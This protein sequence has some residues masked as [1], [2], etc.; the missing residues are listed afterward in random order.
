M[1]NPKGKANISSILIIIVL[2]YGAFL[3][4]KF[5]SSRVTKTQIKTEILEKLGYIRGPEFTPEKGE[6]II[7]KILID[8]NL[9]SEDASEGEVNENESE[10]KNVNA[11][12]DVTKIKVEVQQGGSKIRF[13]VEYMDEI[14]LLLFKTKAHYNIEEEM[15]NYF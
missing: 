13:T 14:D 2:G 15:L 1:R 12:S 10:D 7:R 6:D 4:F 5:I 11:E 9:Y 8:H 3:A